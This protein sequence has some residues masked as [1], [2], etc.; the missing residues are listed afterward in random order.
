MTSLAYVLLNH[1]HHHH[2]DA[3]IYAV[4]AKEH[5]SQWAYSRA[6]KREDGGNS[7]PWGKTLVALN[8]D[9]TANPKGSD[10]IT[11]MRKKCFEAFNESS[12]PTVTQ[13]PMSVNGM[14]LWRHIIVNGQDVNYFNKSTGDMPEQRFQRML[15]MATSIHNTCQI[16]VFMAGKSFVY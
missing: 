12:F 16:C 13:R 1:H 9:H 3:H 11:A 10:K 5:L 7:H 4:P 6:R 8:S 2:A 14:C 15:S